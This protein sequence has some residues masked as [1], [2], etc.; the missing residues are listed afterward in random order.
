VKRR[1]YLGGYSPL[2]ST[3]LESL[4]LYLL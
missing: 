2:E 4:Q 1:V 3:T